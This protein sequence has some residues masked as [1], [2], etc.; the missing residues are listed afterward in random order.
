[1]N[2]VRIRTKSGLIVL[3]LLMKGKDSVENVKII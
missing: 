1:M 2:L 3:P